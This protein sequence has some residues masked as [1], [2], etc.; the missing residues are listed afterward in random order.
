MSEFVVKHRE[1]T[2]AHIPLLSPLTDHSADGTIPTRV[3]DYDRRRHFLD[4]KL[5]YEEGG[6]N[7][8]SGRTNPRGYYV[9]VGAHYENNGSMGFVIGSG[10]RF[11]VVD[12]KR[13][14]EGTLRKIAATVLADH[15]NKI[16]DCK[17]SVLAKGGFT[18]ADATST[19]DIYAV[20]A[21]HLPASEIDHHESDLYV[22]DTPAVREILRTHGRTATP[23]KSDIDQKIWLEIPFAYTPFWTERTTPL[24]TEATL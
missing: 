4:V 1:I 15:A 13:Y 21:Q 19:K 2:L 11:H 6:S 7:F 9:S 18:V 20:L 5:G 22:L 24:S 16:E 3:S 23:F 17:A 14:S 8:F 10:I 12:A